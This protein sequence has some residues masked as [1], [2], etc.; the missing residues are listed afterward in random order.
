MFQSCFSLFNYQ[1]TNS[2]SLNNDLDYVQKMPAHCANGE[3]FDGCKLRARIHT[4]SPQS[5]NG[6]KFDGK[7]LVARV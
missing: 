1:K 4:I 3:K 2:V 6:K 5:E 7:E